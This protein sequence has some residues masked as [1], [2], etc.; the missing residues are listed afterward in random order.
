MD[1]RTPLNVLG[2]LSDSSGSYRV[3][4][5]DYKNYLVHS[6]SGNWDDKDES[7]VE[8]FDIHATSQGTSEYDAV[9]A[10]YAGWVYQAILAQHAATEFQE[11]AARE[12]H[13]DDPKDY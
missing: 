13:P 12:A 2:E 8:W 9:Q 6:W 4:R 1:A 11:A 7:Q 5:V 10:R 3:V